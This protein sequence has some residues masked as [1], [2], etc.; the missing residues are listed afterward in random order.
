METRRRPITRTISKTPSIPRSRWLASE[1]C[2]EGYALT[3]D[4]PHAENSDHRD[5]VAADARPRAAIPATPATET[6][7]P[8]VPRRAG[9]QTATTAYRAQTKRPPLFLR[10]VG[11][12]P[13]G[14][15][16]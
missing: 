9:R 8:M 12:R 6:T 14:A 16:A 13:A 4:N 2:D 1:P 7:R 10:T 3:A 15:R 11:V 5:C